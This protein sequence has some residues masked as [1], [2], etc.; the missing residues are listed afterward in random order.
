MSFATLS[1][2]YFAQLVLAGVAY[3]AANHPAHLILAI[4]FAGLAVGARR[5][6]SAEERWR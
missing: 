6:A 1:W 5:A 2:V 4:G 3:V